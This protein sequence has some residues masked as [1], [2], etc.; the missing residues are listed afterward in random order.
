MPKW[1]LNMPKLGLGLGLGLEWK[2]C[3]ILF[4]GAPTSLQMVIAAMKL[5]GLGPLISYLL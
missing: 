5:K 4:W 2:Q 1:W 3:Q